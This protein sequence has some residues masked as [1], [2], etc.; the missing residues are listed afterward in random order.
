MKLF[1]IIAFLGGLSLALIYE[2][3]QSAFA[4][5]SSANK[6]QVER[7]LRPIGEG[8]PAAAGAKVPKLT[9]VSSSTRSQK[10]R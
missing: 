8:A 5:V 6:V 9:K 7:E 2:N 3:A 4:G 1:S 10:K